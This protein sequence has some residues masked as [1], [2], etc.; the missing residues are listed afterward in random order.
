MWYI[1]TYW[2]WALARDTTVKFY[3]KMR[4]MPS[5]KILVGGR[6]GECWQIQIQKEPHTFVLK[7]GEVNYLGLGAP[8]GL[9]TCIY[10]NPSMAAPLGNEVWGIIYI[11]GWPHVPRGGVLLH[12]NSTVFSLAYL[13]HVGPTSLQ[14]RTLFDVWN[15]ITQ[16]LYCGHRLHPHHA[17]L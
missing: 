9:H 3:F 14:Y 5:D 16:N 11:E 1:G 7:V 13:R 17:L 8:P 12:C 10:W 6:G 2:E 15:G 4:K